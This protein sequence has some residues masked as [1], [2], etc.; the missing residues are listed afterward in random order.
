MGAM[1]WIVFGGA[2]GLSLPFM[3][4]R[5]QRQRAADRFGLPVDETPVD[6]LPPRNPFAGVRIRPCH[7]SPCNAVMTV[8]KRRYLA[9][10][11]PS[12]PVPGCDQRKCGCR[13]VRLSDRRTG[14]DR[15]DPQATFGGITPNH[16]TNRR[17][18]NDRRTGE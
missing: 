6:A 4:L 1:L 8:A 17:I 16:G 11:A 13:Y 9:V 7:E 12:L 10:R 5:L 14:D 3:L 15:R 2:V 18:R